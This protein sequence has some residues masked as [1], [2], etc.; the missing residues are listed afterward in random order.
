MIY[1]LT[2]NPAF[3]IHAQTEVFTPFHENLAHITSREA[4]G[5][6]VNLSRGLAA[7]GV[8]N[9]AI[10][11]LGRENG[12]EFR[13]A[14]SGLDCLFIEAE[15][16]IRENLTIHSANQPETRISF[17]GFQASGALLDDIAVEP[18]SIVTV[19]GRTAVP[20]A[21]VKAFLKRLDAKI[22]IDSRSFSLDDLYEVQPW[23]I[24]PNQEEL[25][26][27]LGDIAPLDAAK[28]M[29]E[30]GIENV[31]ISL[32]GDGAILYH[33]G[34]AYH[35]AAP[36]ITPVSTVGAGDS[37][38]AGFLAAFSRGKLPAECLATAVAF[39]SAACLT[40]GTQPP[41]MKAVENFLQQITV[42]ELPA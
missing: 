16:R 34:K 33:Q 42:A 38:I 4:G 19:T 22:V 14:L 31:M 39:G 26:T 28:K 27:Y 1:T 30:H 29:A 13:K 41:D 37:M 2:L 21:D 11:L 35:A 25:Q 12:A 8:S 32:G 5:K 10:I 9:R 17:P 18:D 23:L 20:V 15:G 6:G 7:A 24:K 40:E 36:K 3:D